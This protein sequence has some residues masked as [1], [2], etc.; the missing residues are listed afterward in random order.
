VKTIVIPDVHNRVSRVDSMLKKLKFDHVV[1]L[2][3]FFDEYGDN[4]NTASMTARAVKRWI[5]TYGDRATFLFGNHD[6]SYAFPN[7]AFVEC[8][9][10]TPA[11]VKAVKAVLKREHWDKFRFHTKVEGFHLT[12]AGMHQ[13]IFEHP[14][15]GM[16]DKWIAKCCAEA[17]GACRANA[18]SPYLS[19]G[20]DRGGYEPYSGL[21]WLHWGTFT[22][23]EGIHQIVGHTYTPK[24][25]IKVMGKK[26]IPADQYGISLGGVKFRAAD[27]SSFNC[28]LDTMDSRCYGIIEDGTF[29]YKHS[30]RYVYGGTL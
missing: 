24:P 22:P 12:H 20:A 6:L 14:I 27:E 1:F 23:I 5:E 18:S 11:K 21:V 26:I 25:A 16:S 4:A 15:H 7:N 13:K 9:G 17:L 30:P 28:C 19:W 29:S 3:D 2:G 10:S 8:P